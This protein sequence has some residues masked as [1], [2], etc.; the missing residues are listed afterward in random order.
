MFLYLLNDTLINIYTVYFFTYCSR[1]AISLA[2]I[3]IL[4]L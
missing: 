2:F 1:D 3:A 4:I